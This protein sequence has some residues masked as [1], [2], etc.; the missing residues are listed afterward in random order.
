MGNFLEKSAT[1]KEV[2]LESDNSGPKQILEKY[3]DIIG[4]DGIFKKIAG[5]IEDGWQELSPKG[6]QDISKEVETLINKLI[7][8]HDSYVNLKGLAGRRFYFED[9]KKLQESAKATDMREKI[10]HDAFVDSLNILSRKMKKLGLDNSWRAD[11]EIYGLTPKAARE[12]PK[13]W[14]FKIFR[15]K[16]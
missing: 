9:T 14:M 3:S 10:L 5:S 6:K 7:D 12:K 1:Q 4:N 15:E 11:E 8:Y 16:I 13:L 2:I